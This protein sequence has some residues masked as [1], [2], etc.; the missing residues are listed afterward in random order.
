MHVYLIR[1][2][3]TDTA[4]GLCYGRTDVPL[5]A[6]YPQ[7]RDNTMQRLAHLYRELDPAA[8]RHIYTS[9]ST[10]CRRLAEDIQQTFSNMQ[11]VEDPRLME[12]DFGEWEHRMWDEIQASDGERL[13]A[14][15]DDY[16]NARCPHGESYA[17]MQARSVEAW[18]EIIHAGKDDIV[19]VAHG[20][21]IRAIM[22]HVLGMSLTR[23]FALAVERGRIAVVRIEG[24]ATELLRLN[25]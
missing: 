14:W 19:V 16:V 8:P 3:S 10:R 18:E 4:R 6:D 9:P 1:H 15:S 20:G 7:E 21:S 2:T 12:L 24:A 22:A 5:T 25:A 13:R 23:S 17:D 11:L